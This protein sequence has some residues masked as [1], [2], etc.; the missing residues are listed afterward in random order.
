MHGLARPHDGLAA[1]GGDNMIRILRLAAGLALGAGLT[2]AGVALA[3]TETGSATPQAA[4]APPAPPPVQS[5]P[6]WAK[7]ETPP[8]KPADPNASQPT[9]SVDHPPEGPS[10]I[11]LPAAVLG[12]AKS[13]AGC[14]VV[15]CKD[16]PQV[17]GSSES[18]SPAS[19]KPPPASPGQSGQR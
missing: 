4:P 5:T 13:A 12:Y 3:Q 8:I 15:G 1:P 14:V 9:Y 19:A 7:S 10:G 6:P 16:G 2:A 18:S 11:Y 17:S